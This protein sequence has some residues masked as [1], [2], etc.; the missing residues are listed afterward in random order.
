LPPTH[1]G[2]LLSRM[3][4]GWPGVMVMTLL[5]AGA[6]PASSC[7]MMTIGSAKV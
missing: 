3:A 7:A 5:V 6:F 2:S 4:V 1:D